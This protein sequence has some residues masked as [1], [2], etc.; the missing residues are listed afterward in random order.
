[1]IKNIN[2]QT[3]IS[4][5]FP[6]VLVRAIPLSMKQIMFW[7]DSKTLNVKALFKIRNKAIKKKKLWKNFTLYPQRFTE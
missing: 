6:M 5:F 7:V 1:M 4:P 2:A 3:N